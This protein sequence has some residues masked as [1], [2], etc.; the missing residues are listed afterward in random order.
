MPFTYYTIQPQ[1]WT[2]SDPVNFPSGFP[3]FFPFAFDFYGNFPPPPL[4]LP[5]PFFYRGI[6][7]NNY[8]FSWTGLGSTPTNTGWW[9]EIANDYT[10]AALISNQG[11]PR[12]PRSYDEMSPFTA[13]AAGTGMM[14]GFPSVASVWNN[15]MI[16]AKGGYNVGTDRPPLQIYDGQ[17]DEQ[18]GQLPQT[19]SNSIP[20]AIVTTLVAN[21]QIFLASFD[22]GTD[23]TSWVGRVFS[24]DV[25]TET[26]TQLGLPFNT[27]EL[28][29]ALAWH[30]GRLWCG[31]HRQDPTVQGAI[32]FF[33]PNIDTT[34]TQDVA[35]TTGSCCSL[36]SYNG[37]LYAGCTAP[38][39]TS[40]EIL[41][42]GSNN[43]WTTSD[44]GSGTAANNAYL[45]LALYG[46]NL[47]ASYWN[48]AGPTS[49]IKQFNGT[50]WT[51]VYTGSGATNIPYVG[52]PVDDS[53]IIAAIGG[54]LTYAGALVTSP[55]GSTWTDRTVFLTQGATNATGIPA[56]GIISH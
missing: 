50:S 39:G 29:Y 6:F 8:T 7:Y 23:S 38:S 37:L 30:N 34:W 19:A 48:S 14:G 51:T 41:V 43:A 4:L 17:F 21:G 13:T 18:I 26:F 53:N 44:T 35:L 16:Y 56:F 32:Y 15:F 24:F 22:S 54:G 20:N 2:I 46:T 55:D 9:L 49:L 5:F 28:P 1:W 11:T 40:A 31:T 10:G 27:G 12:D 52:F 25:E 3:T 47:Y 33:R 45:A 36:L 42:R